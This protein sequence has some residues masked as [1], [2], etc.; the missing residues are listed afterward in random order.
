MKY[1]GR[2]KC[3]SVPSRCDLHMVWFTYGL[4]YIW[5]YLHMVLFTY[6]LIYIWF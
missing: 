2:N 1:S 6:G 5:F 4:I 3:K